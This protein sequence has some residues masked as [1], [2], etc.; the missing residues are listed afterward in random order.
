MAVQWLGLWAS[1]AGGV[2]LISGWG[3]NPASKLSG[4]AKKT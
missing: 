2:G 1:T 3:T 4:V